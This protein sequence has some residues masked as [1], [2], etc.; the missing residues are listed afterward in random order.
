MVACDMLPNDR[1]NPRRATGN[2]IH[3]GAEPALR[4]TIR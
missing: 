3:P 1:V 4:G 2:S